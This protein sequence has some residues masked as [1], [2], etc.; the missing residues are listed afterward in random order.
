MN[1]KNNNA[2]GHLAGGAGSRD[3]AGDQGVSPSLRF[4]FSL[5]KAKTVVS[6]RFDNR[7]SFNGLSF[8]DFIILYQLRYAPDE[9]MRRS[10]LAERVGLTASGV[11]RML[12][13]MEKIGLIKRETDEHD[14]RVSYVALAPGG[15]RLYD[16]AL[17]RAELLT[18]D[19]L[20]ASRTGKLDE[21][22]DLLVELGKI[23]VY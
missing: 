14:G 13:P 16:D 17:E 2:K 4:L 8:N 21:M 9:K 18:E 6:R 5:A 10:E 11:T 22:N 12:L 19:I 20:P 7:L 23:V 3:V 15:K 1:N